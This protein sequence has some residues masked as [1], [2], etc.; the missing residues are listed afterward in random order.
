MDCDFGSEAGHACVDQSEVSTRRLAG[1]PPR[2][3]ARDVGHTLL[4]AL[5]DTG[6]Y[7]AQ[8]FDPKEHRLPR[9]PS[10][11]TNDKDVIMR[12]IRGGSADARSP[13]VKGP[14]TRLE[15][16]QCLGPARADRRAM[17]TMWRPPFRRRRMP[18]ASPPGQGPAACGH[19]RPDAAMATFVG[20]IHRTKV[21]RR[22]LARIA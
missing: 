5:Q 21:E 10:C 11:L 9:K 12:K 20:R 4:L 8:Q 17:I 22:R 2:P 7:V 15:G 16:Q 1:S 3:P 14:Q 6:D 19:A 13:P 18:R